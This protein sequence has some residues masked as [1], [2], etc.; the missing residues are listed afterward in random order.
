MIQAVTTAYRA[1]V[2]AHGDP[3]GAHDDQWIAIASLLSQASLLPLSERQE[4]LERAVDLSKPL[5]GTDLVR[6]CTDFEWD[7]SRPTAGES[8]LVVSDHIY[9]SG[10][11]N[12]ARA[13]IDALLEADTNLTPLHRGRAL[14]KRARID[15]RLGRL[16]ESADQYKEAARLARLFDIPELRVRA[17]IGFAVLSHVRGNYPQQ[18]RYVRRAARLAE[19]ERLPLLARLAHL[20][21]MITA[22][23]QHRFEDA[24]RHAR[25]AY[26][27]SIGNPVREAEVL[28]N[29]GQVCLEA[30]HFSLAEQ[31]FTNVVQRPQ[32]IRLLIPV[33]GGLAIV[34]AHKSDT[35]RVRWVYSELERLEQATVTPLYELANAL[36]ET[37]SAL[38]FVRHFVDAEQVLAAAVR[39]AQ[40]RGYHEVIV[41]ADDLRR[42]RATELPKQR[43]PTADA[44]RLTDY[45][46]GM[47]AGNLPE[48]VGIVGTL[49]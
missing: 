36:L 2:G 34:A 23:A 13:T 47:D 45:L 17:W 48:H 15:A 29:V 40:A 35:A 25:I 8:I 20:G 46:E 21:L 4:L 11:L 14:A 32:P 24:F 37:A 42:A 18:M 41:K 6:Q 43:R 9:E 10:A 7:P 19:R 30:G 28:T 33:L 26:Q 49:A 31:A 22:G 3:F 27:H 44:L 12:L 5:L 16:D 39:I 1:D 38:V